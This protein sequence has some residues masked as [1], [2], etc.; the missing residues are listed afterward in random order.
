MFSE[1]SAKEIEEGSIVTYRVGQGA[2][3]PSI[4]YTVPVLRCLVCGRLLATRTSF[5]GKNRL[6]PEV[7]MYA[8]LMDVVN[9]HNVKIKDIESLIGKCSQLE[10]KYIT[11]ENAFEDLRKD[12]LGL[13][14]SESTDGK[15]TRKTSR[16]ST[17]KDS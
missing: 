9:S 11:L 16:K 6:D 2:S 15:Q 17:K 7:Q 10:L 5:A 13:K 4:T 1:V 12:L 3:V 14:N 8:R